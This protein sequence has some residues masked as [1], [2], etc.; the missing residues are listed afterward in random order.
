MV[1]TERTVVRMLVAWHAV[2]LLAFAPVTTT[3]AQVAAGTAADLVISALSLLGVPY[4]YGGDDPANGLD[5]SGLVRLVARN[6]FGIDLPRQSEQMSRAG[7][8]VERGALQPGDLVFFDTLG[9]PNSHVGVYLGDGRFV[10]A[11]AH[12]GQVRIEAM[13]WPYW[14]GRYSGARR[15]GPLLDRTAPAGDARSFGSAQAD[16]DPF[17]LRKP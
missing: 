1:G 14:K 7:Q 10:H 9:R 16:D 5:C 8:P 17:G 13:A 11:P 6:T 12:R 3:W 4:R 2:A 15:L